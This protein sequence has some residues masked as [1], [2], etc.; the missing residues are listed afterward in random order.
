M[1]A[2]AQPVL[3]NQGTLLKFI[4]DA[5]LHI[6]GAPLDDDQ[7][8]VRSITT[9][10]GMIE[11]VDKFN[12][13]LAREG[14]PPVGLGVGVN[15]GDT[16]VGNIGAKTKFGYDVLGD[17]VSVAARLESQTKSYGVLIIVGPDTVD[18]CGNNFDWWE[19]DNIAVKGK[20]EPLRIYTIHKQTPEHEAFLNNYYAGKW[21]IIFEKIQTYKDAAPQM[22]DYYEN[23]IARMKMGKPNDWNGI[24]RA[25]SK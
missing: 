19:L 10:L 18:H 14:K 7:H 4:G 8:A 24:Y 17:P 20:E 11:A 15:T 25:T 9:A 16:L 21:E 1:T 2:I 6:H 3:D 12:A 5:S 13:E 22:A 23:M